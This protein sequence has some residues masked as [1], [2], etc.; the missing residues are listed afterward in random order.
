[1]SE[2]QLSLSYGYPDALRQAIEQFTKETG[3]QVDVE[4][5]EHPERS[6]LATFAIHKTGPDIS[7]VGSTWLSNL[8][9]MAAIRP[10]SQSDISKVGGQ[11]A[12]VKGNWKTGI[13]SNRVCGIPWRGDVRVINYRRDL[14]AKAGVDEKTAFS[15]FE[16]LRDTV[17]KLQK[18]EDVVPWA[19]NTANDSMLIHVV[20][21]WIWNAGGHLISRDGHRTMFSE[22]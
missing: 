21:P 9:S 20:T 22:P 5:L 15:S 8:A 2:L 12:F 6:L 10:F 7:E 11:N 13:C 19:M 17:R 1:M 18:L 4:V 3:I 14:L 16:N